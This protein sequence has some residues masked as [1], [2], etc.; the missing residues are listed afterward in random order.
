MHFFNFFFEFIFYFFNFFS[1]HF[2]FQSTIFRVDNI[3]FSLLFFSKTKMVKYSHNDRETND[4]ARHAI[5]I[6][7][8]FTIW[9]AYPAG[10]YARQFRKKSISKTAPTRLGLETFFTYHLTLI[11]PLCDLK[12]LRDQNFRIQR[13][14]SIRMICHWVGFYH[15]D[16]FD[17]LVTTVWSS[18]VSGRDSKPEFSDS[19]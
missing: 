6:K 11:W 8:W 3:I 4:A 5:K 7:F 10:T 16:I 9:F 19:P 2:D 1:I 18:V 13:E 12:L 14:I 17:H 15:F